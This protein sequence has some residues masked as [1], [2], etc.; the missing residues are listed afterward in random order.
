LQVRGDL[1]GHGLGRDNS[2]LLPLSRNRHRV[3]VAREDDPAGTAA[4][5]QRVFDTRWDHT[6]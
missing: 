1:S 6:I 2:S 5:E 3:N 4:I